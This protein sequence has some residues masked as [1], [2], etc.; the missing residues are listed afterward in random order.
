M[1]PIHPAGGGNSPYD[2]PSAFAGNE[3]LISLEDLVPFGL[4]TQEDVR[5]SQLDS[6]AHHTDFALGSELRQRALRK[7]HGTFMHAPPAML[8]TAYEEFLSLNNAWVWD[9]SLFATLLEKFDFQSFQT[10]PSELRSRDPRALELAHHSEQSEI[11]FRVFCQFLFHYQWGELKRYASERGILLMGDIPMFVAHNS[12]DVWANQPLFFLD[13]EGKRTVQAGVPP[14]YFSADGQLWGNPLYRWDV[15]R[16]TDYG[17]W[18]D[19]LR[20]ELLKFDAVRIDHFIALSRYWEIPMGAPTAKEGRYVTVDG[21]RFLERVREQLGG[22]PFVAEDL[23]VITAEVEFLRD[24]FELPGM[25]LLHFAF[26]DGAESYL[27]HR[28]PKNAVA[29]LG[30]HDNNTTRGWYDDLLSLAQGADAGGAK[31]ARAQLEKTYGYAGVRDAESASWTMM[32]S[33]MASSA[34][35]VIVTMQDLLNQDARSRMNVPGVGSGNWSYRLP[36]GALTDEL[37]DSLRLMT[38]ATERTPSRS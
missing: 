32:R 11:L 4:V 6:D 20:R 12:A 25:R 13:A 23:G 36:P 5:G 9:F 8:A 1:L 14:D 26:T 19:R 18:I 22:L 27:P 37:A 29:Y 24:H 10:W 38:F 35:T 3:S 28:H 34:D 15:M 31:W 7:A 33:L 16:R 30:T 17:W 2:S 21:A